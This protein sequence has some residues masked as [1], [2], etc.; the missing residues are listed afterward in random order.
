MTQVNFIAICFSIEVNAK[1]NS[2][3]CKLSYQSA[4]VRF[5]VTGHDDF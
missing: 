5:C 2:M 1:E 3:Q 4:V